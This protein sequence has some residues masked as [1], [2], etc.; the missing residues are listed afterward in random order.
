[1]WTTKRKYGNND[2]RKIREIICLFCIL[3]IGISFPCVSALAQQTSCSAADKK[4]ACSKAAQACKPG[5]TNERTSRD[6]VMQ[7]SSSAKLDINCLRN[8]SANSCFNSVPITGG[9]GNY[10]S[11]GKRSSGRNHYGT[12]IGA[13]NTTS[14][15]ALAAADGDI[16]Y[17]SR[18]SSGSGITT[19]INHPKP[20]G[21]MFHTVYR[22][23][24]KAIKT[25][26]PVVKNEPIGIVGGSN[27]TG[28][29]LCQHP[30]QDGGASGCPYGGTTGKGYYQIHL[31]FELADGPLT[32]NSTLASTATILKPY[33]KD[34]GSMCGDCPG[35]SSDCPCKGNCG[36]AFGDS[37]NQQNLPADDAMQGGT[38]QT[39][40]FASYLDSES[41]I[42]CNVFKILFNTAS[43]IAKVANDTLATPSRNLV[44]IGF[45]IWMFFY[46]LKQVSSYGGASTGEMLKGL[47]YQGFRVAIVVIILNGSIYKVMD[48]TLNPVMKTGMNFTQSLSTESACPEDKDYMQGIKGYKDGGYE[49]SDVDG[50]LSADLGKSI[51]CSIKHLEDSTG[52]LMGL[53][54][55]SMC[56]GQTIHRFIFGLIPGLGY[57]STG[58]FLWLAGLILLLSFPW[59]LVDCILQLCI[60]AALVPCAI[61]AYAF[62]ITERYIKIIWN[63]F[64]NAMF[65]FVFMAIIVYIINDQF[66][67]WI[68]LDSVN[69]S[70]DTIFITGYTDVNGLAWWGIGAIKIMAICFLCWTFFDEAGSM[71]K[72]FADSPGLGGG[73]GIGRMVG[74]TVAGMAMNYGAKPA[75]HLAGKGA[76]LIGTGANS[77]AGNWARSK[78]NQ[79]KGWAASQLGGET[80]RD[81]DG[82]A[83]GYRSSIRLLGHQFDRTVTKDE[84]GVWTQMKTTHQRSA[85][86]KAFEKVLDA[87]GNEMKDANGNTM[88][89]ARHRIMG[90]TTGREAMT[91]T[92]DED[93][94]IHYQTADGKSSFTMNADGEIVSYKTQYTRSLMRPWA[95]EKTARQFGTRQ[96]I[97]DGISKTTNQLD[98]H[99]NVIG[100]T[101]EFKNVTAKHLVN[102]DG[103]INTFAFNQMKNGALNAEAAATHMVSAVMQSRGLELDSSFIDRQVKINDDGSFTIVQ[104]NNNQSQQVIHASMFGDQMIIDQQIT[105]AYGNI[106][107]SVSNGIQSKVET[108]TAQ[109]AKPDKP[110]QLGK[111]LGYNYDVRYRMSDYAHKNN[112]WRG[113]LTTKGTWGQMIDPEKAMAGFS[114]DDFIK[115]SVQVNLASMQKKMGAVKF[116]RELKTQGTKAS[117]LYAMLHQKNLDAQIVSAGVA[118][119]AAAAQLGQTAS[120]GFVLSQSSD[121]QNYGGTFGGTS[122]GSNNNSDGKD[123][124]KSKKDVDGDNK[125]RDEKDRRQQQAEQERQRKFDEEQRRQQQAE[126]ER[127][128][129]QEEEQRRQQE[130]EQERQKKL[131]E[132]QRRKQEAEQ[133]QQKKQEAE[134]EQQKKQEEDK[135]RQQEQ[136]QQEQQKKQEEDQR[137]Q[138]E[139]QQD[140]HKKQEAEKQQKQE[141]A[142]EKAARDERGKKNNENKSKLDE[143]KSKL[144]K[145]RD[146]ITQQYSEIE[147]QL[148]AAQANIHAVGITPEERS[149]AEAEYQELL[150]QSKALGASL[151]QNRK[152][153]NNAIHDYNERVEKHNS[154]LES[155][156]LKK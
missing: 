142:K 77:L 28:G 24:Y 133:E 69:P 141:E 114:K 68:G 120:G 117:E 42:F 90:V 48:L 140:Q 59:C 11:I 118:E 105:D 1:M 86:D 31:H 50:G 65:N 20:C 58:A 112:P 16:V 137:R 85:T 119:F 148:A 62:K 84:N 130:A 89:Q 152:E 135:R 4:D 156:K 13:S 55:Y 83:I 76:Q 115:H 36:G 54:K 45:L 108:Y 37:S 19:G 27:Y 139:Q 39:C 95:H 103:T 136:Q 101:T 32:G 64:M 116:D 25:G 146:G 124:D 134:Q 97:N 67:Q 51:V 14:A 43:E 2:M 60:A 70:P 57:M 49:A 73:G 33:C 35:A 63:F 81:A 123:K 26:G 8:N 46:I 34:V 147:K 144:E 41:C 12:D 122:S 29:R 40:S 145:E 94:N 9:T 100:T 104:T 151:A 102:K 131:D 149:K 18:T 113:P 91:A 38:Q 132:E 6:A 129:K 56:L 82:K 125:Y 109:R 30:N 88:Y 126:Q 127:Q 138:Q 111:L 154:E 98:T 3:L 121:A 155:K 99:G 143:E 79:L 128:R 22:H 110:G 78:T 107:H 15:Q 96:T 71:A 5:L 75:M 80:I 72:R 106:T 150:Q 23:Q 87:N 53:G 153:S 74:G 92:T 47:L 21:G 66:K 7:G 61:A 93:G 10:N 52:M 17:F 44:E